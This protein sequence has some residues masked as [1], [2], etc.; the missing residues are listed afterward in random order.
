MDPVAMRD[1]WVSHLFTETGSLCG[2]KGTYHW[3]LV[4]S[5]VSCPACRGIMELRVLKRREAERRVVVT[6]AKIKASV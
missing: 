2:T 5:A 1:A 6:L 4:E 3:S